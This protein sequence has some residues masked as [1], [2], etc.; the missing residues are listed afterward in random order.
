MKFSYRWLRDYLQVSR[1][2]KEISEG[3][4][5]SGLEVESF[6]DMGALS[7]KIV[8]GRIQ[9]TRLHPDAANLTLCSV[10]IG[11]GRMLNIVCGAKNM[12]KGDRVAVAL[13]GASLANG[14]TIRPTRIR[15][16]VSEGMICA[17][18]ELGLNDDHSG[19][20]IL[21]EDLPVGEPFDAI[22][23]IAVTPNRGDCLS[24]TGL[25]RDLAASLG[26]HLMLP[27][28]RLMETMDRIDNYLKVTVENKEDCPRYGARFIRGVQVG[29]SPAWLVYR[30]ESAG[31]RS[32]NNVID[33]TNYIMLETGQPIHAFDMDRVANRHIIVRSARNGETIETL[34]GERLSLSTEDL[35][36]TDPREPIALAGIMGGKNSGIVNSTINVVI[37]CAFFNPVAI[38]KTSRRLGKQ[39]DA[40]FR[41]EREVD[42]EAIPRVL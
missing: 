14:V 17:G 33:A 18:D 5:M 16:E 23:E 27:T 3:F 21:P 9:E 26:G 22:F 34:D 30:L 39:T 25:A 10:D 13:E 32:I 24:L 19:V 36:I 11:T 15:G 31:L 28:I 8:V 4:T 42:R 29:P 41:F 7:G 37:E 40:S 35:L 38:R 6:I 12:K 1:T 2:I 20:L